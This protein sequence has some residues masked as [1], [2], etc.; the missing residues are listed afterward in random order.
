MSVSLENFVA[1]HLAHFVSAPIRA[2][3]SGVYQASAPARAKSSITLRL[4]AGLFR[5]KPQPSH[6][7]TAM[8]TPQMRCLETHQSGRVAI[9]FGIRPSPQRGAPFHFVVS[10]H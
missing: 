9:T 8:G 3:A 6:K 2:S 5:G 7:N 1:P 4:S 10:F